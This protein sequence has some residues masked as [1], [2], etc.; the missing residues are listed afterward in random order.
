VTCG[1]HHIDLGKFSCLLS[2]WNFWTE[3]GLFLIRFSQADGHL[4]LFPISSEE[5]GF[6]DFL[7]KFQ[8]LVCIFGIQSPPK[9][10]L[11]DR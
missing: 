11:E 8:L 2:F 3:Q 10:L 7:D 6:S 1:G 5:G 9:S 4:T